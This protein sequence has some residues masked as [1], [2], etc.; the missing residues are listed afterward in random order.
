MIEAEIRAEIQPN[1]IPRII[2]ELKARGFKSD[3]ITRRT[4]V[5]CFGEV[6]QRGYGWNLH[7]KQVVDIRCR[8][9]NGRCEI[10]SKLGQTHAANRTE[11]SRDVT[12]HEMIKYAQFI[13][14]LGFFVKVGSKKTQNL[15]Q[16]NIIASLVESPSGIAYI[17]LEIGTTKAREKED[18]VIL[19]KLAKELNL[20]L[21]NRKTFHLLC[22]RL[23]KQDDWE[24]HGTKEDIK[25]LKKEIKESGS[26]R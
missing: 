20:T 11:I 15:S 9:T 22:D 8:I 18:I 23:T 21:L 26:G 6:A 1:D 5:M 3:S 17:E 16:K 13:A 12:P 7:K 10:V 14:N 19:K 25:K 4:S 2:K 24:F